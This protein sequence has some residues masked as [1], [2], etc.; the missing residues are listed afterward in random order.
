MIYLDNSATTRPCPEAVAAAR[1]AATATWGNPSAIH[2]HGIDAACLLDDARKSVAA[3]LRAQPSEI[4]FTP[5]GTAANNTALFGA[6]Y[7]NRKCKKI[8]SG[9]IEHPSVQQPLRRLETEGFTIERLRHDS[10]GRIDLDALERAVD[11]DT[12]L[13]TLM[14]VNNELGT[15]FPI[16]EISAILRCKSPQAIFHVDAVQ[17]FGKLPLDPGRTGVDL[18]SMSAHKIH[19]LKG[20]GALYVR[21]G[22][23]VRPYLLGGGQERDLVSGTEPTPAI[24]AFGAA[25]APVRDPAKDLPY[26]RALKDALLN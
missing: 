14:A 21:K 4:Y 9:G 22:L 1:D 10:A 8:V 2:A 13:V 12:G 26:A 19:G 5:G 7:K 16:E 3:V 6:A 24:A 15:V 23:T 11:A 18:M 20:A 25:A 17:A